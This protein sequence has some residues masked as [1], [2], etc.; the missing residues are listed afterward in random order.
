MMKRS[1]EIVMAVL[2][3]LI[4]LPLMVLIAIAIKIDSP[5]PVIFKH[6]RVGINRRK[7]TGSRSNNQERREENKFGRPFTLYKFRSMCSDAPERF[8]ELYKYNFTKEQLASLPI[9]VLM[10]SEPGAADEGK[11]AKLGSDP[12]LTRV[13]RWLRRSSLDELPNFINVI[14]GDMSLVGPRADIAKNIPNYKPE[15]VKKL[16]VKPG[17][18]GLAQVMGRGTL[19]FHKTNE[20]DVEYVENLSFGL[21]LKILLKTIWVAIKGVGS[22]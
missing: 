14:K 16:D 10:G 6:V 20:L 12:R 15:H 7:N 17:V 8:P 18:T 3:S 4:T 9:K 1:V 5:G 21:Y 13:G 11:Q 22:Y 19:S 2:I